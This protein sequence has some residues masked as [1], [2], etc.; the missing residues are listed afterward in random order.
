[1]ASAP[2][3]Q[4]RLAAL[5]GDD[6]CVISAHVQDARVAVGDIVWRPRE[7]R[8]VIGMRRLDLDDTLEGAQPER[9]LISALRFDRVLACQSRNI[10]LAAPATVLDLI[11]IE[12]SPDDPP[13]G[14]AFLLF[15]GGGALRLELECL[16]CELADLG[17][18]IS[19]N[20]AAGP[21]T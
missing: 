16:E 14:N 11:G 2:L 1:M 18:E 15:A 9:R 20:T 13:G 17:A 10:D 12:F 21:T 6:L 19:D 5:D 7:K 4:R 8:L 3:T